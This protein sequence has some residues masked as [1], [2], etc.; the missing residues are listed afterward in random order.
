MLDN[1]NGKFP[2]NT[3]VLVAEGTYTIS[4]C[5]SSVPTSILRR[6]KDAPA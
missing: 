1:V 3:P 6:G 2:G 5:L 4:E